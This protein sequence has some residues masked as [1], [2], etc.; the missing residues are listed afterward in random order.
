M[1]KYT[2]MCTQFMPV[3]AETC[4]IK[5]SGSDKQQQLQDA[6]SLL[7]LFTGYHHVAHPKRLMTPSWSARSF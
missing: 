5:V 1:P 3:S 6:H 7:L 4:K 2:V